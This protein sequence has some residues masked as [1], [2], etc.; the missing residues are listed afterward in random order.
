MV[1][2]DW[3]E[4]DPTGEGLDDSLTT[5]E[6]PRERGRRR[7]V[8]IITGGDGEP[9]AVADGGLHTDTIRWLEANPEANTEAVLRYDR[10]TRPHRDVISHTKAPPRGDPGD[11]ANLERMLEANAAKRAIREYR[12]L[13]ARTD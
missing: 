8:D 11:P 7:A 4:D 2:V 13:E 5:A 12:D 6:T 9:D 3:P 1:R 10:N